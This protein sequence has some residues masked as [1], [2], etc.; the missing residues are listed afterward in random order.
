MRVEAYQSMPI[1]PEVRDV[2]IR[3]GA[4]RTQDAALLAKAEQTVAP[5]RP[6]GLLMLTPIVVK[7]KQVD[8]QGRVMHSEKLARYLQDCSHAL[9]MVSTLKQPVC[10][11]IHQL[12]EN[13]QSDEA[14]W[15]DAAASVAADTGLDFMIAAQQKKL[16]KQGMRTLC[17][18]YSPGYGDLPLQTQ[19]ILYDCLGAQSLGIRLTPS[20]ML[21]PEKSVMAICGVQT[22]R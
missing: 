17:W 18:R 3:I 21:L 7:D 14:V 15:L 6:S 22:C 8:V 11:R 2:L 20:Y 10:D 1:R 12:M 13:G 5:L 19:Q 4:P 9:L 16:E